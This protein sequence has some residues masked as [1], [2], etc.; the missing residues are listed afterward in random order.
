MMKL[1]YSPL[2]CSLA[3]RIVLHEIG[4]EAEYLRID[5]PTNRILGGGDLSELNP[6][7]QVPTLVLDDGRVLT[8]NVAVLC[9]LADQAKARTLLPEEGSF[10]RYQALRWL[11][12]V[13]SELHKKVLWPNLTPDT[14]EHAKDF[15]R[16]AAAAP[17]ARVNLHLEGRQHLVGETFGVADAYLLWALLVMPF[18][19]IPLEP[20]PSISAYRRLHLARPSVRESVAKEREEFAVP[21]PD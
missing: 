6:M 7:R 12:L 4:V 13:G 16:S 5:L 11:S 10:E 21:F 1:L 20:F 3:S 17:L 15:A 19:G 14:P 9:F 8:E 2:A 18:A